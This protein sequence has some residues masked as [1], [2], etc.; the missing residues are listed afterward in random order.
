MTA[1][2]AFAVLRRTSAVLWVASAVMC[3]IRVLRGT[4][5]ILWERL[6]FV[7]ARHVSLTEALAGPQRVARLRC[8][9][10]APLRRRTYVPLTPPPPPRPLL[11]PAVDFDSEAVAKKLA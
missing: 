4:S 9:H 5:A 1:R 8:P 11:L 6:R 7:A 3:A 2:C 10:T